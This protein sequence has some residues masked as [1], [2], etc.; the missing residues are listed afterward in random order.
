MPGP[1]PREAIMASYS[2]PIQSASSASDSNTVSAE[3]TVSVAPATDRLGDGVVLPNNNPLDA[4][5]DT[6]EDYKSESDNLSE[7]D[8]DTQIVQLAKPEVIKLIE[9]LGL[10]V[11]IAGQYQLS[12]THI[13][14]DDTIKQKVEAG[15]IKHVIKLDYDGTITTSACHSSKLAYGPERDGAAEMGITQ[16]VKGFGFHQ[17]MMNQPIG[18]NGEETIKSILRLAV[19]EDV[20]LVINSNHALAHVPFDTVT[21]LVVEEPNADELVKNI[22]VVTGSSSSFR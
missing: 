4:A 3:A 14:H 21:K 13:Y 11:E 2:A 6:D 15:K 12:A 20:L 17:M 10:A 5:S 7:S 19:R 18:I 22:A 1:D 16:R 8:N 9:R